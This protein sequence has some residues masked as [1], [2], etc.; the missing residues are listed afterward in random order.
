MR[1]L[2]AA[3]VA[4]LIGASSLAYADGMP[5]YR[6]ATYAPFSWT[7]CYI[8]ADIGGAWNQQDVSINPV[9][10]NQG[11]VRGS[12]NESSAIRG[13]YVGCNYQ[14][15]PRWVLGIEGDFSWMSL[16]DTTRGSNLFSQWHV[17]WCGRD[18]LEG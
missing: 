6:R 16:A 18:F 3:A 4:L 2:V 8:G 17:S 10:V 13:L 15:A 9:G 14:F 12:L 11:G 7:G 5:A 1:T